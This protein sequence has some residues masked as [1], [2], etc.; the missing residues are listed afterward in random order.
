M[1]VNCCVVPLA[2]EGFVGVTTIDSSLAAVTLRVVE[3]VILPEVAVTVAVPR[4]L[5]IASPWD[6]PELEMLT[7]S[8]LEEDQVTLLVR[9][10][11]LLSVYMPVAENWTVRPL[12]T[13]PFAGI[14]II[15]TSVAAVTVKLAEPLMLPDVQE[16]VVVPR[17]PAVAR[18]AEPRALEIVAT[19][20]SDEDHVTLL[21]R[22]CLVL[23]LKMPVAVKCCVV[24]LAMEY[25]AGVTV[26]DTRVA[27]VTLRVV[28]PLVLPEVAMMLV[29]PGLTE[30][31]RPIEEMMATLVSDEDVTV[32]G[33]ERG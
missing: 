2:M 26:I 11:L 30:V 32:Q 10:C 16:I 24:P 15:D 14:T 1:A 25:F 3:P 23:S 12:A 29:A 33:G 31:A 18:P 5:A 19:L 4:S 8:V 27:A 6:P 28:E 22:S 20:V 21:V 7:A 13:K 17:P 9:F